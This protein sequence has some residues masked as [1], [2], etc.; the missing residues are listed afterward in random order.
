[1]ALSQNVSLPGAAW[2][3]PS[4]IVPHFE[5]AA[6]TLLAVTVPMVLLTIV[7]GN[8][9]GLAFLQAQGYRV[10]AN[11]VTVLSGIVSIVN[12]LFG[13]HPAGVGRTGIAVMASPEAGPAGARYWAGLVPAV[14]SILV[15]LA[16]APTVSIVQALPASFVAT[17]AGLAVLTALQNALVRAFADKLT[18]GA[19]VAFVVAITPFSIGGITS[20]FWALMAGIVASLA[21]ERRELLASWRG[22]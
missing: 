1:M 5:F 20:A 7:V 16:A 13:G 15:A 17:I 11:F 21:A 19:L 9:Q 3:L 14:L 10:R 4:L 8:V 22:G 6:S 18:F 12:A 2:V